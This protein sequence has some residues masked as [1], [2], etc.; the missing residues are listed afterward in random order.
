MVQNDEVTLT[1]S[2]FANVQVMWGSEV[3]RVTSQSSNAVT[4]IVPE[5]AA[6]RLTTVVVTNRDGSYA[7]RGAAYSYR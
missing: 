1:G 5:G 6:G 3:V 2:G 4:V 7:I